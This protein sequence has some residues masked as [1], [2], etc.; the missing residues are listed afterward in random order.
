MIKELLG[1]ATG[2]QVRDSV[3]AFLNNSAYDELTF[4]IRGDKGAML[5]NAMD[6]N[7][8]YFYDNTCPEGPYGGLRG[9]TAIESVGR[10]PAPGGKFLPPKS[11]IGWERGHTHCYYT[12]LDAVAHGRD[13]GCTI[14]DGARL[15][16]LM[17]ELRQS[18][19]TGKWVDCAR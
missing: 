13:P 1:M 12:F 8:L 15:Q 16:R 18:A 5:W 2:G 6:A 7:Y 3:L 19:G 9:F 17:D 14:A 10:Y 4:E 11:G